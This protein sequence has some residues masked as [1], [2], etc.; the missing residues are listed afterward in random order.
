MTWPLDTKTLEQAIVRHCSPTLAALK[1]ASL[2]TFPGSFFSSELNGNR[3]ALVRA[4]EGCKAQ[5]DTSQ[6]D[7]RVLAWRENGAL[8]YVYRPDALATSLSNGQAMDILQALGYAYQNPESCLDTLSERLAWSHMAKT[9]TP[10]IRQESER[11]ASATLPASRIPREFGCSKSHG[12]ETFPH[13]IGLF[14]GY[15]PADVAAFIRNRGKN[16]AALG[17]WKSYVDP[18]H[19]RA[20]WARY[21]RCTHAYTRTYGIRGTLKDLVVHTHR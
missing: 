14:L 12:G 2:F 3:T 19:A 4:I 11:G 17:L 7:I 9:T 1:P 6:V 16:Y 10:A 13:E 5:L 18:D 20:V 8:I 15:P 21:R